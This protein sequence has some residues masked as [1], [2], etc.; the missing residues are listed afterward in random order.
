MTEELKMLH[1]KFVFVPIVVFVVVPV[2]LPF[3]AKG[4]MLKF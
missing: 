3:S 1:N 4:T 2:M